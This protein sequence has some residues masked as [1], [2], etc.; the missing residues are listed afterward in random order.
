MKIGLFTATYLDDSLENVCKKA[1]DY[2]YEAV[3]LPAFKD[4]NTHLDI[5]NLD[6]A[7]I[8]KMVSDLGLS[9]SALSNH[10]ESLLVLGPYGKDTEW[11]HPGT[12][13]ER[14]AFGTERMIKTAEA[15]NT[16][17][18]P[19]VCGFIGCENFGRFFPFPYSKGWEEMEQEFADRWGKI[20]D[21]YQEYGGKFAHEPH[22]N[23]LVYDVDTALKSV[24]LV[25]GHPAWGFNFDP[26]NLIYLGIDVENFIDKLAGRIYH[27]HAKDG[28]V[29]SHN[30]KNSGVIPQGD[31]Q[32]LGRGFRFRI[33]G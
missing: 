27:V 16:L 15:A 17:E 2:G 33:P 10:T 18:V 8:K 32:R 31:W 7:A 19:V 30:V 3:E 25:N 6:A 29:V 23:Q 20:L 1:A 28:E 26:A 21:K 24:A 9:I 4:G 11:I 5:D 12:K 22:P 14:I 13:E